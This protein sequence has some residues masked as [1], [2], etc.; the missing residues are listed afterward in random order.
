MA[1][2]DKGMQATCESLPEIIKEVPGSNII[3]LCA[4]LGGGTG[5]GATQILL[6]EIKRATGALVIVA[7]LGVA[8]GLVFIANH[9]GI[10]VAAGAFFAGALVA[11][12]KSHAIARVLS[13]PL[14]DMFAALFIVSVGALMHISMLPLFIA[15]ALVPI[16]T[17]FGTKFEAVCISLPRCL[18][19]TKR[20]R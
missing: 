11:E 9:I 13:M 7:V 3:F 19:L 10:P 15:P 18:A 20:R 14:C 16:A 6:D 8:F 4:G 17:S 2:P 5:T 12:S 1:N